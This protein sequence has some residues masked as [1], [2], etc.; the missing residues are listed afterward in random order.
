[1]ATEIVESIYAFNLIVPAAHVDHTG[2][3]MVVDIDAAINAATGDA[4][5]A[6]ATADQAVLD[7]AA[8]QATADAA[9]A[10][11]DTQTF[12]P[13]RVSLINTDKGT[14]Y[15]FRPLFDGALVSAAMAQDGLETADGACSVAI[16]I[17]GNPVT[18]TQALS[19]SQGTLDGVIGASVTAGGAFTSTDTI[20]ITTTSAN[21]AA[22]FGGVTLGYT[23]D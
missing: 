14:T 11:S 8:A 19:F 12:G 2:S 17:T 22:A 13:Q 20:R 10:K 9:V 5:A 7:A 4:A 15:T 21:T 1:M 6:Q 3:V 16:T 18:L 23:R